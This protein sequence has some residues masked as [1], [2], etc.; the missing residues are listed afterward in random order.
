[1]VLTPV[2][3]LRDPVSHDPIYNKIFNLGV[4]TLLCQNNLLGVVGVALGWF[5]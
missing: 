4:E 5:L 2:L 1:M 3:L